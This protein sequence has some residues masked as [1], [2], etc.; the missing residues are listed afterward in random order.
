LDNK[1]TKKG[2]PKKEVTI[3]TGKATSGKKNLAAVSQI[4]RKRPPHKT[5][6]RIF[7]FPCTPKAALTK[8]GTIRPTKPIG[9]ATATVADVSNEALITIIQRKRKTLT[10]RFSA[11]DSPKSRILR[12]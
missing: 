1:Y 5:V 11:R 8:W 2:I 10:P 7:S 3:P 4:P 6:K 12:F 9:P